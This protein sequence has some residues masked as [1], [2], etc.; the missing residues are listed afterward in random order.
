VQGCYVSLTQ[1]LI[2]HTR[3]ELDIRRCK[4]PQSLQEGSTF[5]HRRLCII[6]NIPR[7]EDVSVEGTAF[8]KHAK[9][10][11]RVSNI[12]RG[13]ICVEGT[14]FE[15]HES[16]IHRTGNIPRRNI[17]VEGCALAEHKT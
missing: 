7:D 12:P 13:N 15:E 1:F 16:D 2:S 6:P 10:S 4:A 9:E 11:H 17:T 8:P 14:A 3:G 5:E